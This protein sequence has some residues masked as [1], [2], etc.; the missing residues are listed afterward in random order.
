MATKPAMSPLEQ[1][2]LPYHKKPKKG[3]E[4]DSL[5]CYLFLLPYFAL[6]ITFVLGPII[7]GFLISLHDWHILSEQRQFVGFDNYAGAVRDDLFLR[8]LVNTAYFAVLVVPV[9]NL[10]SLL[11]ALGVSREGRLTTFYRVAFYLPVIVSVTVVAIL[12]Q[13][14]YSTQWGLINH[15]L[16]GTT[17]ALRRLPGLGEHL[18]AYN[19]LPWLNSPKMAMPSIALL[20]VWWG[21]GGNMIIYLA[22]LRAIPEQYYEAALL[23]GASAWQRFRAVTLPLLRPT[24]LF[25]F[26]ISVIGAFQVF[27]QV[28]ILTR[29]GPDFSTYTLVFYLYQSGFSLYKLGYACAVAYLLFVVVLA[30]TLI[31]FRLLSP[32]D[33][34]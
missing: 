25:C 5:K 27:G 30:F 14:L 2:A 17:E 1:R 34:S 3:N 4:L 19:P 31:Q 12:W 11:L 20:S 15:Y 21:A 6:F 7:F 32:K 13:W 24:L 8:S 9:G 18:P 16:Y 29:G 33:I 26:V 22:G 23:D 28:M 10:I